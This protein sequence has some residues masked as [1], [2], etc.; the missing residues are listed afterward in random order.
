MFARAHATRNTHSCNHVYVSK[1]SKEARRNH[2]LKSRCAEEHVDICGESWQWWPRVATSSPARA[3]RALWV[4]RHVDVAVSSLTAAHVSQKS[5]CP[6]PQVQTQV[7]VRFKLLGRRPHRLTRLEDLFEG[8]DSDDDVAPPAP[9]P[10]E[11]EDDGHV[12][13]ADLIST[14]PEDAEPA[15]VEDAAREP[16]GHVNPD[17]ILYREPQKP[18]TGTQRNALMNAYIRI[19]VDNRRNP[20][21]GRPQGHIWVPSING[22]RRTLAQTLIDEQRL[23]E[24]LRDAQRPRRF[25]QAMELFGPDVP[26]AT[27]LE[28]SWYV[29]ACG[30]H[31]PW[32]WFNLV[33][34]VFKAAV[35]KTGE[36][37]QLMM[38]YERDERKELGHLQGIVRLLMHESYKEKLRR[39]LRAALL[40][41]TGMYRAKSGLVFFTGQE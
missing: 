9:A 25:G 10:Q 29:S 11:E 12:A 37:G 24:Q 14:T 27:P 34:N 41:S 17:G 21:G 15:P 18:F 39:W 28:I 31:V 40:L 8:S 33:A 1:C 23:A 36:R 6:P 7:D 19:D 4:S 32:A 26:N 5:C 22:F 3:V 35:D 16:D 30:H 13:V 20:T 2:F 38:S